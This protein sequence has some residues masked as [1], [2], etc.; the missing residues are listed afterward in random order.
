[1]YLD[2]DEEKMLAGENGETRQKMLD[3]KSVV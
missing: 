2:P 1:M 3:R